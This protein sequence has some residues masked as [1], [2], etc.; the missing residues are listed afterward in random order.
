MDIS[1]ALRIMFFFIVCNSALYFITYQYKR[2]IRIIVIGS[3]IIRVLATLF[4]NVFNILPYTRD[5]NAYH[6]AIGDIASGWTEG[7]LLPI[8]P[9]G[10]VAVYSYLV[11]PVYTIA[12]SV[13]A[14]ELFNGFLSSLIVYNTYRIAKLLYGSSKAVVVSLLVAIYPSLIHYTSILMRDSLIIFVSS[15]I[16]YILT[17][18][19]I[20]DNSVIKLLIL[21][22][23]ALLLRPENLAYLFPAVVVA[24]IIKFD[25]RKTAKQRSVII[26]CGTLII[27]IAALLILASS[28]EIPA[29]NPDAL[30]AQR[31]WLARD[32]GDIGGNYLSSV[33]FNNWM[34]VLVFIPI[35]A[36]YFLLV[37]FPWMIDTSNAFMFIALVE[38]IIFL[39]PVIVLL[40]LRVTKS[41]GIIK[42]EILLF[43]VFTSGILSYG[44]VEGNM[45]PAMRHRLQF[46][47]LL[48]ILIAP[49]LPAIIPFPVDESKGLVETGCNR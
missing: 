39:Y 45:G 2:N 23:V 14:I 4:V 9:T 28:N 10:V 11:A 49:K 3:F 29:L 34:D 43:T 48:L 35:G 31:S 44:I 7:I 16:V 17:S 13:L 8:D 36:I 41:G 24:A 5:Y 19:I 12:P 1:L 26:I 22:P 30:S 38:N 32:T 27:G 21:L 6:S 20:S 40:L 18:W 25:M 42:T 46:T 47:Y 15:E 33:S 37:P